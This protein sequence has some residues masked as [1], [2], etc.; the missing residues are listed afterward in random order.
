MIR[1]PPR[2]T[3]T[4]TLFPYTT[5]VRS[6]LRF[7]RAWTWILS[8]SEKKSWGL[9]TRI[10]PQPSKSTF[11]HCPNCFEASARL[12][13][14]RRKF[15]RTLPRLTLSAPLL[16]GRFHYTERLR[17]THGK[18]LYNTRREGGLSQTLLFPA[19]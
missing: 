18:S 15:S 8:K 9:P 11:P 5:L 2:S 7:Q 16:S 12:K 4:D 3:R 1:R 19:P 17:Q 13:P 10:L 14:T 6:D